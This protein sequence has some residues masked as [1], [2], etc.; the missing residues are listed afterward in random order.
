MS[1][2]R[3]RRVKTRAAISSSKSNNDQQLHF[4]KGSSSNTFG[5]VGSSSQQQQQQQHIDAADSRSSSRQSTK[6]RR[7]RSSA[8]PPGGS[9]NNK[10]EEDRCLRKKQSEDNYSADY[11]NRSNTSS[12]SHGSLERFFDRVV[13]KSIEIGGE[14]QNDIHLFKEEKRKEER[15]KQLRRRRK[16]NQKKIAKA[17]KELEELPE[18]N[19]RPP[20]RRN[21]VIT[22]G[23][24]VQTPTDQRKRNDDKIVKVKQIVTELSF[25]DEIELRSEIEKMVIGYDVRGPWII[26][27][28][29]ISDV[30]ECRFSER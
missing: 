21:E 25:T 7:R 3:P 27:S 19:V 11:E 18:E 17:N 2:R 4:S 22:W 28:T 23:L 29:I 8:K 26:L 1:N 16:Y 6:K 9:Q 13:A 14:V 12:K 24:H 30:D 20:A 10:S 15:R 5:R